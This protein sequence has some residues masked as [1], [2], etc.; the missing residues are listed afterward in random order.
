V[1][2]WKSARTLVVVVLLA[3]T[4]FAAAGC[5]DSP[6][7]DDLSRILDSYPL[8]PSFRQVSAKEYTF[9]DGDSGGGVNTVSRYFESGEVG[10]DPRAAVRG[11]LASR[12]V[13]I[14]DSAEDVRL[15]RISTE[16][17]GVNVVV[18]AGDEPIEVRVYKLV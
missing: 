14:R 2:L 4:Q 8:P 5:G 1:T 9:S 15:G 3:A 7:H 18:F 6:S 12:G 13:E 10:I 17:E 11:A 16:Y